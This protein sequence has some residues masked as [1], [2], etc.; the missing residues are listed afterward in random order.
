M[1]WSNKEAVYDVVFDALGTFNEF[2]LTT[3]IAE[4]NDRLEDIRNPG[5]YAKK[6]GEE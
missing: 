3:I 2:E 6:H 4:A 5:S 1:D